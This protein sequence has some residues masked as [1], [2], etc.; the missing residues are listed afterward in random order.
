M[1]ICMYVYIVSKQHTTSQVGPLA[2]VFPQL[3]VNLWPG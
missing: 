1:Y 2:A 3:K